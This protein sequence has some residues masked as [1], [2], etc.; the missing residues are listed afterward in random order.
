M[1]MD[2]NSSLDRLYDAIALAGM[3]CVAVADEH[4]MR[5]PIVYIAHGGVY[6]LT[7]IL[8]CDN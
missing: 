2:T 6:V 7:D 1:G 4:S 5:T 8:M 3:T